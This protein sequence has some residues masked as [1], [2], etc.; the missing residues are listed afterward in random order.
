[1][2]AISTTTQWIFCAA[3]TPSGR[4][5]SHQLET[6]EKLTA[7]EY[8]NDYLS[9]SDETQIIYLTALIGLSY[10]F[11]LTSAGFNNVNNIS[12]TIPYLMLIQVHPA[13]YSRN[14][15]LELWSF[16]IFNFEIPKNCMTTLSPPSIV[17]ST[18]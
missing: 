16:T 7:N 10:N 8:G 9:E 18:K 14:T 2:M 5:G 4:K 11:K 1:M 15:Y 6:L 12:I 13:G 17:T 3:K